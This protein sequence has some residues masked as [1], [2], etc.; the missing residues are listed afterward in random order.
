MNVAESRRALQRFP[1]HR[2]QL[3]HLEHLPPRQ[4]HYGRLSQP[5]SP[6]LLKRLEAL[7]Q[8]LIY[9]HQ[10]QT[11]KAP[12]KEGNVIVSA[13]AESGKSLCYHLP[14]LESILTLCRRGEVVLTAFGA[15]PIIASTLK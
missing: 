2:A 11:I 7:G 15:I 12:R 8:R 1:S 13:Y 5:L 3:V 9:S 10:A 14:V 4:V 6:S